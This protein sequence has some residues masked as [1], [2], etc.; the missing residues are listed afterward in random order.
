MSNR[1]GVHS[2]SDC[3]VLVVGAGP[4]GLILAAELLRRG[5][6]VRVVDKGDGQALQSR[7]LAVHARTLEVFDMMGVAERFLERGQRIYR[8]RMYSGA[9]LLVTLDLTKNPSRFPFMLNIPQDE[10]ERL[11][12]EHVTELGGV[13]EQGCELVGLVEDTDRVL[14][15]VRNATGE[16]ET[17]RADYLAGCD[18]AHSRVRKE[19]GLDFDGHP[20]DD[21][22]LLADVRVDWE[23]PDNE[24]QAFFNPQRGPVIFFP[25]RDGRWRVFGPFAGDRGRR[26][27]ALEEMQELVDLRSPL[28]AKLSDPTWLSSFRCHRR[29]THTYRHGRVVLAGDAVHVHSPAGG[30]GMNTGIMDAHN[31]GWKLALVATARAS[32]TLLE[33]YGAERGPVAQQ[34]LG[35]THALVQFGTMRQPVKVALRDALVPVLSRLSMIQRRT[36]RRMTQ[37]HVSYSASS[38]TRPGGAWRRLRPGDR[39]PDLKLN[40]VRLFEELRRGEHVR[41]IVAGAPPVLVRPDGYIAAVG[42]T[43]I[44]NYLEALFGQTPRLPQTSGARE[45][46]PAS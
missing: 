17:I 10:T 33:T 3:Q 23:K 41:V 26:P 30:Q 29:S 13:I 31:L 43:S 34:V 11:L 39:M 6:H 44:A 20:Y 28:R 36:V 8:F 21:D 32:D 22:W 24:V 2:G 38:L 5:V 1:N 12:R 25:M 45:V 42:D 35:L 16:T 37:H 15:T 27:P 40:G 18:G 19:L 9:R 4:T 46:A 14:A 7:A